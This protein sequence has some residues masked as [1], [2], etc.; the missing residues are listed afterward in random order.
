MSQE[1]SQL[2][3]G[4]NRASKE[5]IFVNDLWDLVNQKLDPK[6]GKQAFKIETR[7]L[8][9]MLF[10]VL[11]PLVTLAHQAKAIAELRG[12]IAASYKE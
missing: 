11:N 7:I 8:T 9:E 12:A 6:T 2:E 5:L 1:Q 3:G 10:V 4:L